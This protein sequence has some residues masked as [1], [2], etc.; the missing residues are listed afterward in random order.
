MDTTQQALKNNQVQ[1]DQM[2]TQFQYLAVCN[3]E[4]FPK[5]NKFSQTLNK[6][7]AI[8]KDL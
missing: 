7:S 1:C 2:T 8:A 5:T 4:N 6:H 3:I